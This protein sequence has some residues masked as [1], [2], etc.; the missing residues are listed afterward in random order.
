ML[1]TEF[2][3]CSNSIYGV[4]YTPEEKK[5]ENTILLIHGSWGA[6][7]MWKFYIDS[8]VGQGWVVCA[9]DLTGHGKSCGTVEGVTMNSYVEDIENVVKE[10]EIDNPIMIGHSM[11]GLLVLMYAVKNPTSSVVIIDGSPSIEIQEESK[12]VQY[13]L[14]YTAVDV[15]MPTN[16]MEIMLAF[17]DITQDQ[18][19]TM[20][21]MLGKESG[22]AR[23]QRKK[24]ISISKDL[25]KSPLLFVGGEKGASVPFGI[26]PRTS[27]A[28]AKYYGGK[29]TEIIGATHPGI[30]LGK[31]A[32]T[33]VIA[34]EKWL[35]ELE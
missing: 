22:V 5:H 1:T 30:L 6:S 24:G 4:L 29:F 28:A 31:H 17:P 15:G 20:K 27:E 25:L 21:D 19:M 23:S 16:P 33:A 3:A 11:G 35:N 8:F 10:L 7:W 12:E 26:G 32:M 9:I 2:N 14:S 13:P 34:I 18:L